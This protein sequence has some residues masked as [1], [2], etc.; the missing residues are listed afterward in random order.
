[1]ICMDAVKTLRDFDRKRLTPNS[2]GSHRFLSNKNAN[3]TTPT[4]T[5]A[6]TQTHTHARTHAH[7]TQVCLEASWESENSPKKNATIWQEIG[8]KKSKRRKKRLKSHLDLHQ[9]A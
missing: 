6:N 5:P 7:N 9:S 2:L 1:M 3:G 8:G 4:P